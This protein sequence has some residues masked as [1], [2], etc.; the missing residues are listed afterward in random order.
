VDGLSSGMTL[1]DYKK[2][3][4]K[5]LK[6]SP[7]GIMSPASRSI[8]EMNKM[9]DTKGTKEDFTTSYMKK[10]INNDVDAMVYLS[11]TPMKPYKLYETR[12][13]WRLDNDKFMKKLTK[14]LTGKYGEPTKTTNSKVFWEGQTVHI[15]LEKSFGGIWLT[16]KDIA[17]ENEKKE[18][19]KALEKQENSQDSISEAKSVL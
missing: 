2:R 18:Y 14:V 10:I 15:K 16:Y 13:E 3:L 4:A 8:M 7:Y 19:I 5:E 12:I 1:Q 11:F 6:T 17:I 9:I